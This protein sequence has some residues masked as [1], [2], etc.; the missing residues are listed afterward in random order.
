[1]TAAA[2][3]VIDLTIELFCGWGTDVV[4]DITRIIDTTTFHHTDFRKL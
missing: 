2:A 4:V 1:M 3:A